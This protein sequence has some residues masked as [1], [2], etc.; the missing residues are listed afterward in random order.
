MAGTYRHPPSS[1][2]A[3][4]LG[5]AA[6]ATN[7][8]TNSSNSSVEIVKSFDS[9]W[10]KILEYASTP[11]KPTEDAVGVLTQGMWPQGFA[12]LSDAMIRYICGKDFHLRF[13]SPERD[14]KNLFLTL[15]DAFYNDTM[16]GMNLTSGGRCVSHSWSDCGATLQEI[17]FCNNSGVCG[18]LGTATSSGGTG[19]DE[20]LYEDTSWSGLRKFETGYCPSKRMTRAGVSIW[21]KPKVSFSAK[22]PC[23]G[24]SVG[25]RF[26][27]IGKFRLGAKD[28]THASV[29][30]MV[31]KQTNVIWTGIQDDVNNRILLGNGTRTDG[32]LEDRPILETTDTVAFGESLIQFGNFRL[33]TSQQTQPSDILAL[34][35]NGEGAA[36]AKP[37]TVHAWRLDGAEIKPSLSFDV[38][39]FTSW[40]RATGDGESG[41]SGVA[42]GDRF[43]QLGKWR[44]A[45][46]DEGAGLSIAHQ[47][48]HTA[49]LFRPDGTVT[50]GPMRKYTTWGYREPITCAVNGIV[51]IPPKCVPALHYFKLVGTRFSQDWGESTTYCGTTC[52]TF[53]IISAATR[54]ANC[55]EYDI[56]FKYQLVASKTGI[57][58][59]ELSCADPG[60]LILIDSADF[61]V[62]LHSQ[63]CVTGYSTATPYNL[64]LKSFTT[65]QSGGTGSERPGNNVPNLEGIPWAQCDMLADAGTDGAWW[66][67]D[68]REE[69]TVK[70]VTLYNRNDGYSER[71]SGIDLRFGLSW[72]NYTKD[73]IVA[74]NIE[75][76][77]EAPRT[78]PI[79][80]LGRYLF[81]VR[82]ETNRGA[83]GLTLCAIEVTVF[84]VQVVCPDGY[85]QATAA[86]KGGGS[87]RKEGVMK[88]DDTDFCKNACNSR[89]GCTSF[90]YKITTGESYRF[91]VTR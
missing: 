9:G 80:E 22:T 13:T 40:D 45:E 81:V 86:I 49:Y 17:D 38:N 25:D 77:A 8:S 20:W 63:Y 74:S 65:K 51:H 54:D 50:P 62:E 35:H 37:S 26:I 11:Y 30:N 75:V 48:F 27:Q 33:G 39:V 34:A 3:A 82:P 10:T 61:S 68:F 57:I 5:I 21:C 19:C 42:F 12:K 90:A 36:P 69:Y 70:E 88:A 87:E 79:M 71:L 76:A 28:A 72:G 4:S 66:G 78:I 84:P 56:G 44:V 52:D 85:A 32:G 60:Q 23:P 58:A 7:A 18:T 1:K 59:K 83:S 14:K 67:I 2:V 16:P 24:I 73:K 31:N 46:A 47:S 55:S 64:D 41:T 53:E 43:M 6:A 29:Q 91:G 15:T 89:G